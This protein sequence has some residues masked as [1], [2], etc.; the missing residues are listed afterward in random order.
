[1]GKHKCQEETNKN[2]TLERMFPRKQAS[3]CVEGTIIL[4]KLASGKCAN[5]E[6]YNKD[7]FVVDFYFLK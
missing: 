1:M 6:V 4:L 5:I 2:W 3:F 7:H